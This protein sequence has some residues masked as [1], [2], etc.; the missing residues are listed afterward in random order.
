M[1]F[2]CTTLLVISLFAS[3]VH[4]QDAR[5]STIQWKTQNTLEPGSGSQKEEVTTFITHSTS[6][7]EWKDADGSVTKS[8]QVVDTIGEWS[9]I[10][11]E[12]WLQYE[13]TDGSYSGSVSI[14]K[15]DSETK[16]F[17]SMASEPPL[18][19]VLTVNSFQVL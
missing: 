6:R 19:Y 2:C 12:G 10:N 9:D 17:I 4:A 15:N 16:I 13:V 3:T 1:K 18:A 8:F 14:R 5:S 7:I 11:R